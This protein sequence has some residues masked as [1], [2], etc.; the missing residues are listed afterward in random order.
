MRKR[1][2]IPLVI[3]IAVFAALGVMLYLRAEAPPEA[4]RLLP[5]SD[6]I[7]YVNLKPLRAATHFDKS[8]ITRSAD[9]QHFIDATGIVPERDIDSAAFALHKVPVLL[10][11]GT[12]A[13][14]HASDIF[15][16]EVFI[17][18]FDGER[19]AKYLASVASSRETYAGRTVYTIPVDGQSLRVAQLAYDTIAVSN[20]PTAEQI[21]SMLDRSRA[22]AL[23]TPGCSLLAA[24]FH[25]VPL[26]SQA[27]GVGHIGLPFSHNGD[28]TVLG[29]ALPLPAD[30]DL[31]ASLRYTPAERVLSGG[32]V[33]LRVEEIAPDPT[34]AETTVQSLSVILGL[35]RG[36]DS[37]TADPTTPHT[38]SDTALRQVI[39]ST[40]IEQHSQRAV[41][42]ATATLDQVKALFSAHDPA[43]EQPPATDDTP[44]PPCNVPGKNKK[45]NIC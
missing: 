38:P 14:I 24:R 29:V 23:G 31:V 27:W 28:I 45:P 13:P 11:S 3:A 17:G 15:S 39:A 18:R 32:A 9:F 30:S 22:S 19:L 4:A 34:S 26:L 5:E 8:P 40:H 12:G 33:Q 35:L 36:L 20:M 43:A 7:L 41:L 37:A 2:L 6:A 42:T 44:P 1:K 10:G 25:D 16:S 21:H